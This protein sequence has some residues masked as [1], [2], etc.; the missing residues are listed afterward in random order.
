MRP[1][2]PPAPEVESFLWRAVDVLQTRGVR[3][4]V[5]VPPLRDRPSAFFDPAPAAAPYRTLL[6][7]LQQ[8]GVIVLSAPTDY[9]P[10]EFINAGHLKDLGAQRYSKELGRQL[11][12]LGVK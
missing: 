2:T 6:V 10:S 5:T 9:V 11:V 12:A 7:R 8:R 3:V 1:S 4:F